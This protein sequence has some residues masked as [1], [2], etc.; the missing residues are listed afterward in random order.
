MG[1]N[2]GDL[3]NMIEKKLDE[4]ADCDFMPN[5]CDMLTSTTGRARIFKRVKDM[6]LK[7]G[8]RD[9]DAALVQIENEMELNELTN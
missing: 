6:V 5:V 2:I 7:E 4:N 9:I 8:M 3:D 1:Y